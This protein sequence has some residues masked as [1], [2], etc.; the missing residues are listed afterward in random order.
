MEA[1][2]EQ[3]KDL[4]WGLPAAM[5]CIG[6]CGPVLILRHGAVGQDVQISAGRNRKI[7]GNVSCT[8]EMP[9]L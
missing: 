9:E 3:R 8:F 2:L 4:I 1:I 5:G 6:L 7:P